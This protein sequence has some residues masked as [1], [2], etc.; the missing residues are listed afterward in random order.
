MRMSR[1]YPT[2]SRD[3]LTPSPIRLGTTLPAMAS[4]P[5]KIPP[6]RGPAYYTAMYDRL[7]EKTRQAVEALNTAPHNAR[8]QAPAPGH[9]YSAGVYAFWHDNGGDALEERLT[10]TL[11]RVLETHGFSYRKASSPADVEHVPD[12][13]PHGNA[14][15]PGWLSDGP[16]H[17]TVSNLI[18]GQTT[19][20]GAFWEVPTL[21]K[22]LHQQPAGNLILHGVHLL[23]TMDL[24][25]TFVPDTAA[26]H[27][28]ASLRTGSFSNPEFQYPQ[29]FHTTLGRLTPGT[30]V[31]A[32]DA[33]RLL[34]LQ[35]DLKQIS[36]TLHQQ[37][38][39]DPPP[40]LRL[41]HL[42]I[43]HNEYTRGLYGRRPGSTWEAPSP[44]RVRLAGELPPT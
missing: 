22:S 35:E 34:A 19:P 3:R 33:P 5:A 37:E 40:K 31:D 20:P 42:S 38:N 6:A 9:T 23:P 44:E 14:A 10:Q 18:L 32:K 21:K 2:L 8:I 27:T 29:F 26:E 17:V 28:R 24:I 16:W 15:R 43:I 4:P 1:P 25:A 13:T 7:P 11:T 30:H 41:K 39:G 12:T 36:T